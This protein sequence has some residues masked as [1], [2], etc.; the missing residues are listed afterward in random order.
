MTSLCHVLH[1][2]AHFMLRKLKIIIKNYG[3]NMVIEGRLVAGVL[4]PVIIINVI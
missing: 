2:N 1:H 4:R 3:I